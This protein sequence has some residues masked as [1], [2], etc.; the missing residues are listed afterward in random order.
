MFSSCELSLSLSL[1]SRLQYKEMMGL[2]TLF[3]RLDFWSKIIFHNLTLVSFSKESLFVRS[4]HL[5]KFK[6]FETGLRGEVSVK[7]FTKKH[8]SS[9]SGQNLTP[10]EISFVEIFLGVYLW[11]RHE[12]LWNVSQH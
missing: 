3:D 2:K 5:K 12:A 10:A 8:M 6:N 9:T 1:W 4:L 7:P 11:S